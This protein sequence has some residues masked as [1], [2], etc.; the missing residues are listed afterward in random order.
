MVWVELDKTVEAT[1]FC[2]DGKALLVSPFL[3][4][5][6]GSAGSLVIHMATL[7]SL[8]GEYEIDFQPCTNT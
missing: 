8:F 1:D 4:I 3:M 5:S 6:L 2:N 7:S